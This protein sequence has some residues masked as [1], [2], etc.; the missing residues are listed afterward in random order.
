MHDSQWNKLTP[1]Q[2]IAHLVY[3]CENHEYFKKSEPAM[4]AEFFTG[5]S[6]K[7]NVNLIRKCCIEMHDWAKD[8]PQKAANRERWRRTLITWI[9]KETAWRKRADE[10]E[11]ERKQYYQMQKS[12]CRQCGKYYDPQFAGSSTPG[13]CFSCNPL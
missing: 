3:V 6:K 10:R 13:I 1:D 4:D 12:R 2:K 5:L 11:T 7:Y 9:K 8:F